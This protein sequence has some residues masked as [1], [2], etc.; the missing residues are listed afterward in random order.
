MVTTSIWH[1]EKR[2]DLITALGRVSVRWAALDLLLVHIAS[3]ALKNFPAAQSCIFGDQNAGQRRF[4]AFERIIGASFFEQEERNA[5]LRHLEKLQSLYSRR[6]KL[7]HEPLDTRYTIEGKTI[8]S[9]LAFVSRD[10]EPKEAKLEDINRH[11]DEVDIELAALESIWGDL[12]MKYE[13]Q[14]NTEHW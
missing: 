7:T 12:V 8:R 9:H 11:V 3:V 5:I 2:P 1:I 4:T 10:G 13:P 14:E 6:N